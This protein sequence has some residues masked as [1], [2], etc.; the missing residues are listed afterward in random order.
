MGVSPGHETTLR[1]HASPSPVPLTPEPGH[2]TEDIDRDPPPPPSPRNIDTDPLEHPAMNGVDPIPSENGD[3]SYND[4][5]DDNL[6]HPPPD[7]DT[8]LPSD[9]E[10]DE[11]PPG[12][13]NG[14]PGIT[15]ESMRANFQ[16]VQM[17]QE[18]TLKTQFSQAEL[19][20]F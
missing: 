13:D 10:S 5:S 12:E 7:L 1:T 19:H 15:L 2:S 11:P 16:F 8:N 20:S 3:P 18:A 17:V 4:P 14:G 9:S 6:D